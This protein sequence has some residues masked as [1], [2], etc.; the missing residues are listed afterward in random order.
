MSDEF[1]PAMLVS[2]G[3]DGYALEDSGDGRKLERFGGLLIDRPEPQAMWSRRL[4]PQRW[5][6][7]AVFTGD[8]EDT[9]GRWRF[10]GTPFETWPV[11]YRGL[12]FLGRI[13]AFRHVGFF[14]E[15]R[16]HWDKM[17]E[18]LTLRQSPRLLNLFGYTGVASLLAARAG[19]EVTHVDASKKAIGWARENVAAAGMEGAPIRWIV[20]DAR[21]FAARELRRGKTYDAILLD[22][23]KFGRGPKGE[24]WDLFLDLPA[25][26]A[27]CR[28][29]LAPGGFLILT[30]YAVRAS[31]VS[32]H[33]LAAETFGPGVL[34]ESGE[35][36]VREQGGGRM[37]STSLFTRITRAGNGP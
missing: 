8:G 22:P 15:Q 4:S 2:E 26:L 18:N 7:D 10:K 1:E 34:L 5:D 12:A 14:P 11:S 16:L 20:E 31:F 25:M 27:Q 23:P 6:A 19:A 36:V 33:E 17:V 30:A 37:I 3:W 9:A 21:D 24:I 28:D 35:L 29:L 13:T 32:L